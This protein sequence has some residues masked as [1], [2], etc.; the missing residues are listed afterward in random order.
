MITRARLILKIVGGNFQPDTGR[1]V[2]VYTDEAVPVLVANATESPAGS[3]QYTASWA[4]QHKDGYWYVDSVKK[5]AWGA[6]PLDSALSGETFRADNVNKTGVTWTFNAPF[7]ALDPE[8]DYIAGAEGR[9][10]AMAVKVGITKTP[11]GMTLTPAVD[12]TTVFATAIRR[13]S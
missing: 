12:G 2:G 3:G 5:T 9:K 1:P 7:T 11:T 4:D 10:D 6:F 8:G 13:R